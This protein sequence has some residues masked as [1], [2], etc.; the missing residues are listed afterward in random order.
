MC[1]SNIIFKID[2][3]QVIL[4]HSPMQNLAVKYSD[5]RVLIIGGKGRNCY[6]VART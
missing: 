6:D 5:K 3:R 4:S 2:P 1:Y